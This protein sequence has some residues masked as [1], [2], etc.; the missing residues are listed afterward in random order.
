MKSASFEARGRRERGINS[1]SPP[2]P[3]KTFISNGISAV[4]SI[5]L[6]NSAILAE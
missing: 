1:H 4:D 3:T 5:I 2:L 6:S